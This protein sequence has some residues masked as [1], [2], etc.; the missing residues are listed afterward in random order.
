MPEMLMSLNGSKN[1]KRLNVSRM[2]N[3]ESI[4]APVSHASLSAPAPPAAVSS[5]AL[6]SGMSGGPVLRSTRR[7]T[8]MNMSHRVFNCVEIMATKKGCSSCGGR[9]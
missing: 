4:S 1:K 2:F 3:M 7:T 5:G 6:V 8:G 9:R